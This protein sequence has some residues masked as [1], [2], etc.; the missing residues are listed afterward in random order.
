[1]SFSALATPPLTP[2]SREPQPF[3]LLGNGRNRL[4]TAILQASG[5]SPSTAIRRTAVSR[6]GNGRI[7]L[8]GP[9][10]G[11]SDR[12]IEVQIVGGAGEP[13]ISTPVFRGVGSGSVQDLEVLPAA[14]SAEYR[15]TLVSLGTRTQAAELDL[16]GYR[17]VAAQPGAAGNLLTLTVDES[18]LVASATDYSLIED[19][20]AGAERLSGAGR[21]WGSAAGIGDAV[22]AGAGRYGIGA[23]RSVVYR[24]WRSFED[25]AW[26]YRLLPAAARLYRAGERVWT[27]SGGRSITLSNGTVNE[28]YTGIV[29]LRDLLAAIHTSSTLLT[30]PVLPGEGQT[31]DNLPAVA[32]LRLRTAARIDDTTGAGSSYAQGFTDTWAGTN[33]ATEIL[34]AACYA[35]STGQGAGL[36]RTKWLLRGSVSG[37]LGTLQ[38]GVAWTHPLGRC[39]ATIPVRLPDGYGEARGTLGSEVKYASRAEGEVKPPICVEALRTGPDAKDGEW[40]WVYTQR[41]A[42]DCP[43][44]DQ[45]WTRLPG[46]EAC[47][48]SE[49]TT[50][51]ATPG[52]AR[53]RGEVLAWYAAAASGNT[54]ITADGELRSAVHD[55]D[56]AAQIRDVYLPMID[57]VYAAGVLHWSARAPSTAVAQ[58]TGCEPA[59]R[60][61]YL[62]RATTAG[63][64]GSSTP[65]FPTTLGATVSD[66]SV[67]WECASRTTEAE[68]STA[69][70]DLATDWAKLDTLGA[71]TTTTG[72]ASL[73][74]SA[75]YTAGPT[76]YLCKINGYS[77]IVT[78][79]RSG[80]MTTSSL[81]TIPLSVNHTGEPVRG[82]IAFRY[83]EEAQF[84][85]AGLAGT[86]DA[87][88]INNVQSS[89]N[90][91]GISR[92][93]ADFVRRYTARAQYIL[94]IAEVP[95]D[96]S[97]S[98]QSSAGSGC[99]TDTGDA[100]WWVPSGDK[101]GYAPAFT[102][103]EY[104]SVKWAAD[105]SKIPI[106][107]HEFGFAIVVHEG[108]ISHLKEGD[109]VTIRIGDAGWDATY[110]TGDQL[111]MTVLAAAPLAFV[112]GQDGDDTLTWSV[113]RS[114][115]ATPTPY[116]QDLAAPALF[117]DGW[118]SFRLAGGG[119]P[120]ALG[121]TWSWCLTDA[122]W[123][124]RDHPS[125]AWSAPFDLSDPSG[126]LPDGLSLAF[127]PGACPSWLDGDLATWTARQPYGPSG[128][129]SPDDSAWAWPADAATL[130]AQV[131]GLVD[132]VMIAR[133][134][135]PPSAQVRVQV[136]DLDQYLPW[137]RGPMVLSLPVAVRD[138]LIVV[139]LSAANGGAI[140]WLWA[141]EALRAEYAPS[142]QSRSYHWS[143]EPGSGL[144]PSASLLGRGQGVTGEWILLRA[145]SVGDLIDL[146]DDLKSAGDEPVCL[147]PQAGVASDAALV[148]LGDR[149]DVT[150]LYQFADA[151]S[152]RRHGVALELLPY[153][154]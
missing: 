91:P 134:R 100:F 34:T 154:G 93:I 120:N 92:A 72:L 3:R 136:G 108:C 77:T 24:Q 85:V 61:G 17:V 57:K 145:A 138:P 153:Y 59:T 99:W 42:A 129:L 33:A 63:T 21:D 50:M 27:I 45:S 43:C 67:V 31:A 8:Q 101:S 35:S 133:H 73:D 5:V 10:T 115:L 87:E 22:P 62:Y 90:Q 9:Y 39:G 147:I 4:R 65:T 47:L 125:G 41:P 32:D 139:S 1:M 107:T 110:R 130:T 116:A 142:K 74:E 127:E 20:P 151:P 94:A 79:Y 53:W 112:G 122:G 15:L 86:Q 83:Q 78:C 48:N 117:S 52:W 119:V 82:D 97:S 68:I 37:D 12:A 113:A 124:W 40:T 131:D 80:T 29:T 128:S 109:T 88:T 46:G 152:T 51:V 98:Q 123:R 56:L 75:A 49:D 23:D 89:P 71:E 102:N 150:D 19:I 76:Q 16:G 121:D 55:L 54:Q 114:G 11:E 81:D 146:V 44:E 6:T 58:D 149:L 111:T 105:G 135:L 66:G 132:T 96:S 118:V 38:E 14:Q 144:N 140:G 84:L 70:A 106:P 69:L 26:V 104:I 36:G 137:R 28:T 126:T 143:M 95:F 18:A 141:G 13:S 103:R 25:G 2:G 64:T 30:V 7:Q 60:N 148:R